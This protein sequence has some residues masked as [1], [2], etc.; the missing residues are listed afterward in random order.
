MSVTPRTIAPGLSARFDTLAEAPLFKTLNE[1]LWIFS[2]IETFHLLFMAMLGGAVLALNLRLLQVTLI[3]V[4][5]ADV[6]RA[7]RP[8]LWLGIAGTVITGTLMALATSVITL[9]STAFM[10]KLIALAAAILLGLAV[11]AHV[12]RGMDQA[13]LSGTPAMLAIGATV[14]WGLALVLFATTRNLG[15]GALLVALAG[16][17]LFTAL[18]S[19][20]RFTYIA[21]IV[22]L[23]TLGIGGGLFM[24][25]S[26]HGDRLARDLGTG[27]VILAL[28]FAVGVLRRERRDGAGHASSPARLVAFASTLA[29]VTTAAAGRWIGF[30]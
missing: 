6:E 20:R 9:A 3:K 21:G 29:W 12:R 26:E 4:P 23:L 15:A 25:A 5:A 1:S 8:W 7:A 27:A 19:R 17:A 24:P 16:F 18:I 11:A 13:T 22:P 14:L 2:L 30:S 10:V 28:A